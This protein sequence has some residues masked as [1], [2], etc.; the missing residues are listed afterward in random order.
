MAA[1]AKHLNPLFVEDGI[2]RSIFFIAE[3]KYS[4]GQHTNCGEPKFNSSQAAQQA[5]NILTSISPKILKNYF[6]L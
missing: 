5:I 6:A 4:V 2:G 3:G 1:L